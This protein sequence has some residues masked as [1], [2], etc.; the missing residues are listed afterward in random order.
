[1]KYKSSITN[2]SK[3]WP[4]VFF[5]K[6]KMTLILH[7]DLDIKEKVLPQGIHMSNMNA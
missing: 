2:H 5:G 6:K 4:K 7:L 1:M 3:L